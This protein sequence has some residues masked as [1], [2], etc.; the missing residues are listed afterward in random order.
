MCTPI[1]ATSSLRETILTQQQI[2]VSPTNRPPL[3]STDLHEKK[4]S[5][6]LWPLAVL[7][8]YN[9]SGG[10]F[11]IEPSIRAAGNFY[12]ILGFMIFPF[13]WAIPEALVTA[14]LGSA[15]LD[16]SAGVAWV[17]EA[18][19]PTMGGLCGYLGWISGA[20]DNAIYPTLFLEYFTSIM[21]W[22]KEEFGGLNRFMLI[23]TIT[24]ALAILNYKG[25]EIVGNTSLV[26][27]VI[28]MSP[29]VLM[30]IIG[31]PQVVPSR[32]FQ[33]PEQPEDGS[34]LFDDSF[35][36]SP[37]PLPLLS[38]GGILW[39]PYLNNLFWNLNSFDAAASFASE[40]ADMK[41]MY[42][43]GIF[44][45]LGM[46]I[47]FYLV[48]LMIAVGATDY[49]QSDWVDGH[50][51]AVA[52]DIGGK[53]LGG[54]TI[55]AAGISNLAL[56]EA[57]LSADAFQLMGMAEH[58]YLPKFFQKKSKYGTPT[59]GI[60]FGT[61]V[62]IIFGCANFGQLLSL[63]NANYATALLLEYAAF[64]KLRLFHKELKRPYRIPIPDWAAVLL[65]IPP[66][67][68]IFIVFLVSNWTVCI[69]NLCSIVFGYSLIILGESSKEKW[70]F[71]YGTNEVDYRSESQM[72]NVTMSD[73]DRG[74]VIRNP[75]AAGTYKLG[76]DNEEQG[77]KTMV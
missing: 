4:P 25:L 53:W 70:W 45:G 31:A 58:G 69:F 23:A 3:P 75:E 57:E 67:L 34:D 55:F 62:I 37:G 76:F 59:Y 16:S 15:F 22:D 14:E 74:D 40:T 19:G 24:I 27:C 49:S 6:K 28:A 56:F 66:C 12:A 39:R 46:C 20:T 13:V 47:L 10:P 21:G 60:I 73:D 5:L 64:V 41:T 52:V 36:T 51:G 43:R 44:I 42:P 1:D 68:G 35:Q 63:L 9:V 33:L 50:L 32:W 7:V 29:F 54:W 61:L 17:E 8:F 30:T 65:A 38:L 48:P 71:S 26:V 77:H 18:F 2:D 11:G 72:K